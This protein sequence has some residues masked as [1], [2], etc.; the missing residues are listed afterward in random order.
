MSST[1]DAVQRGQTF[2]TCW[3]PGMTFRSVMP[4]RAAYDPEYKGDN[5]MGFAQSAGDAGQN[6]VSAFLSNTT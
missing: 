3:A 4:T 2:T 6:A 1:R 5:I